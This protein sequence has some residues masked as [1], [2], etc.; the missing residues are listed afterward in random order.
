M[1]I[2]TDA[3]ALPLPLAVA[4]RDVGVNRPAPI[5]ARCA[6]LCKLSP[7]RES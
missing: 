1:T 6:A 5:A 2:P 4:Y 3:W 7:N